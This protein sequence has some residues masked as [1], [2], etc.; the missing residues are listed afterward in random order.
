[1]ILKSDLIPRKVTN[2]LV[3]NRI[4]G[5]KHGHVMYNMLGICHLDYKELFWVV[6]N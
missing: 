4:Y 5:E 3:A 2:Y 6:R 1:M